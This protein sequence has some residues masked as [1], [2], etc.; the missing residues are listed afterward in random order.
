M[1]YLTGRCQVCNGT[2]R[3][4]KDD[5]VP[6]QHDPDCPGCVRCRDCIDGKVVSV[7]GSAGASRTSTVGTGTLRGNTI[8][9]HGHQLSTASGISGS[10]FTSPVDSET[11]SVT[12]ADTP[13]TH[14]G[15]PVPS[16]EAPVLPPAPVLGIHATLPPAPVLDARTLPHAEPSAL[17]PA[18]VLASP[19]SPPL[20][21]EPKKAGLRTPKLGRKKKT[22]APDTIKQSLHS[23]EDQVTAGPSE[24]GKTA[25]T[26]G[27]L[28]VALMGRIRK[29]GSAT[30][31]VEAARVAP[32]PVEAVEKPLVEV[33]PPVTVAE[34]AV[35]DGAGPTSKA[36]STLQ[37]AVHRRS[38]SGPRITTLVNDL[39][40]GAGGRTATAHFQS[41]EEL[42][43]RAVTTTNKPVFEGKDLPAL[44][45]KKSLAAR[46]ADQLVPEKK[47]RGKSD[48]F[49][50]ARP[51]KV[52]PAPS[53]DSDI[54]SNQSLAG[55]ATS[56]TS[57]P[58]G[59]AGSPAL[60]SPILEMSGGVGGRKG[61]KALSTT[62]PGSPGG[63]AE[64][65]SDRGLPSPSS[66]NPPAGREH[67]RTSSRGFREWY[68]RFSSE[69]SK[70]RLEGMAE[71]TEFPDPITLESIFGSKISGA[72]D[73]VAC[74]SKA[75]TCFEFA[76]QEPRWVKK[77][78]KEAP[79][80][81]KEKKAV[82]DLELLDD[83]ACKY[84]PLD[85]FHEGR[86]A[87]VQYSH[88]AN[89]P[90]LGIIT[91]GKPDDLMDAL[92][93][94]LDQDMS[95]AEVF[96]A[97]YRFFMTGKPLLDNLIE[98]YN[99]DLDQDLLTSSAP[100]ASTSQET[101]DSVE[102]PTA[103]ANPAFHHHHEQFLKKHRKHI[104]SRAIRVLLMWIKNHWHDFQEDGML[105]LTLMAFLDHVS[106]VSF[107]DGQKMTQAIREQRLSWYTTQYIPFFPSKRGVMNDNTKPWALVWSPEDFAREVTYVDHFL[108]RQIRPDAYLHVL[109]RP[110]AKEGAGRN[111]ALK[112][113]L[114]YIG[115]FRLVAAYTAT[116]VLREDSSKRRAKVIKQAIRIAK[117]CRE[118]QNYN[119]MFAILAGLKRPAVVKLTNAWE[120]LPSKHID[121][122][123]NLLSLM[124]P[125]DGYATYWAEFKDV[126]PPAIPFLAAYMRDLLDI[127]YEAP[128][129]LNDPAS[130][131]GDRDGPSG[132]FTKAR[133]KGGRT[134]TATGDTSITSTNEEECTPP[135]PAD[136]NPNPSLN[137][138]IH[139][140]KYYDLYAIAAEL[141]MF[142]MS[143]VYPP[144]ADKDAGAIVLT[145]MRD[146]AVDKES[147]RWMDDVLETTMNAATPTA[148][149]EGR[150]SVG[151]TLDTPKATAK[152]A[153][154]S[155]GALLESTGNRGPSEDNSEKAVKPPKLTRV[156]SIKRDADAEKPLGPQLPVAQGEEGSTSKS[157][158]G[159]GSVEQS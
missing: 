13:S 80:I 43:D 57:P 136:T 4:H 82:A 48:L 17:P 114:E 129:Y 23:S 27:A 110:V 123:Q 98:W 26:I 73:A 55:G 68:A 53:I 157:G 16:I 137:R 150:R 71:E 147:G 21:E 58:K 35:H 78:D 8:R 154:S 31:L 29:S 158:G 77:G 54:S 145:H 94:P 81:Q 142:R 28:G 140:Q 131:A 152:F 63:I 113:L 6:C 107:G 36:T 88:S 32:A 25:G 66:S 70:Q 118:L 3:L 50:F 153:S 75:H 61:K 126:Q 120:A 39:Q 85:I 1:S 14:V 135:T 132:N 33:I 56:D 103:T 76:R 116:I 9:K 18:P 10:L 106:S 115:W 95:Y 108:F 47:P 11:S 122:F 144:N 119:T 102:D 105:Y 151:N 59:T 69:I 87:T 92:I 100:V 67:R 111:V 130:S 104:Q 148:N 7:P 30:G 101:T 89:G 64:T 51:K 74:L 15:P 90:T 134:R 2:A 20:T 72:R 84:R 62:L 143:S 141:E 159:T 37:S 42:N 83:V 91:S 46:S 40:E 97:T 139:F 124:D 38:F 99:V 49:S 128:T 60:T 96:L 44:P 34:V 93:F 146:F 52:V 12:S 86:L 19:T 112:V 5:S 79:G 156:G 155:S 22:E 138:T 65:E 121:A 127:H 45:D 149:A 117:A 24:R 125:A 133:R 41:I 109:A